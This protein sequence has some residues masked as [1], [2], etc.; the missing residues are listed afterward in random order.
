MN[1]SNLYVV[2]TRWPDGGVTYSMPY[3]GQAKAFRMAMRYRDIGM[4]DHVE[5]VTA[6]EAGE[7]KLAK[8]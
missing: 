7:R 1:V 8:V 2:I 4:V 3:R 6:R 5:I